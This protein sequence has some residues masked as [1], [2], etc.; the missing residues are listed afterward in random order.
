[1]IPGKKYKPEDFVEIGWRYKWLILLPFVVAAAGTVAYTA[2]L[3]NLYRSE[4]T[5]LV[6]PPRVQ[7]GIGA[8]QSTDLQS[9]LQSITQQVMSRARLER[10]ILDLDLYPDER[11]D[12]IMEDV[13]EQMRSDIITIS[14]RVDAIRVGYISRDPRKAQ[15][16]AER[17]GS[18]FVEENIRSR[19]MQTEG[20]DQFLESQLEETRRRLELLGSRAPRDL[21]WLR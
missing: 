7:V 9:R 17:L 11:R 21:A 12:G 2:R 8:V 1:M 5:I 15:Q 19:E 4:T 6:E 20:T 10:L 3:P 16:V 18:M 13:V 14:A